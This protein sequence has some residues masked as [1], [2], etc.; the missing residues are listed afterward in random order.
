MIN[1]LPPRAWT[2]LVMPEQPPDTDWF[3][4]YTEWLADYLFVTNIAVHPRQVCYVGHMQ[5]NKSEDCIFGISDDYGYAVF[6]LDMLEQDFSNGID[7]ATLN[8]RQKSVWQSLE[9]DEAQEGETFESWSM[10]KAT[11]DRCHEEW[12]E[13]QQ[14]AAQNGTPPTH[15]DIPFRALLAVAIKCIP[16]RRERINKIRHYFV[17]FTDN[18]SK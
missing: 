6:E 9:K 13:L 2:D 1:I 18:A 17:N 12:L 4:F 16:D 10:A 11:W 15:A 8:E 7:W 14:L 5:A 3:D